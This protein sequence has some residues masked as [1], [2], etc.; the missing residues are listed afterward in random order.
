MYKLF[1]WGGLALIIMGAAKWQEHP[2]KS[3]L[4][5]VDGLVLS[6]AFGPLRPGTEE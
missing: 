6:A 4:M 3:V 2:K 1:Y 5:V